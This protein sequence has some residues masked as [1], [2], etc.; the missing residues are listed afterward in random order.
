MPLLFK[1]QRKNKL[2]LHPAAVKL[3]VYLKKLTDDQLYYVILVYD[4][5]SKY[6]QLPPRDRKQ[7]AEREVFGSAAKDI[8]KGKTVMEKAIEEYL[9][10]QYDYRRE[11][12][13]TYQEKIEQSRASLLN[14]SS[15]QVKGIL[16][17]NR[18]LDIEITKLQKEIDK[19]EEAIELKGGGQLTEIE[20]WQTNKMNF[21]R[22]KKI[23]LAIT[24]DEK[25]RNR[26]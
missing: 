3:T 14:A 18:L 10:L 24:A 17:G 15:L 6:H 16:D 21:Q 5:Y 2:V 23:Q 9:S 7:R 19:D 1:I 12:I 13:A 4:Y 26:S 20:V 11:M 8:E 22:N 25:Q